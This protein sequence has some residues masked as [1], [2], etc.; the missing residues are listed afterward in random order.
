MVYDFQIFQICESQK[1]CIF[2]KSNKLLRIKIK[3][4]LRFFIIKKN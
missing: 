1:Y 4:L 2:L 3:L